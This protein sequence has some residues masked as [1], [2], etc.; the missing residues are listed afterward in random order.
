MLHKKRGL[1]KGERTA[2]PNPQVSAQDTMQEHE[3]MAAIQL[4]KQA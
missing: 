2:Q 4:F 1:K 3:Q